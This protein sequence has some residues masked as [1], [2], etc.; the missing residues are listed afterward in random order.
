MPKGEKINGS[1]DID[2]NSA[3]EEQI[4]EARPVS[5]LYENWFLDYA[6]Y[7][8]L[9]RAVPKYDDGLKPVQRR[10]LHAMKEMDDG[11]FHKVANIIGQTMQYHPHG[12]AAIGDALVNM[13]QKDMLINT[14]GNWGDTRTG[15]SAAA[16]R[17]IEARLSKFAIDVVFNKEVTEWQNSYD[18]R[19]QEPV[20]LPVK[21]PMLLTQGVEGIAVGLSTKIMP[22]NFCE[23]IK[24]SI[25]SLNGKKTKL[26]PD[27]PSGGMGDFTQYNG[28]SKGGK[29]RLRADIKVV[30]KSTLSIT[31]V[32][33]NTTTGSLIDTILKANV[34]GKIKIKKVEDNTAKDVEILVHLK[35]GVSSD[36]A[37]DALFAFT[38]CEVSI[39]PNCCV[40]INNTPRFLAVDELLKMSTDNTVG[41]LQKELEIQQSVL[42]DKWH[43]SSLERVFIE[44]RIYSNIED[45]ETWEE[46]LSTIDKGLDPFKS[47]FKR[48]IIEE[49]LV[50]LTELK[51]K[52]ISKY[53][54]LKADE[55]IAKIE[56]N[57]EEVQ[58][59][60]NH[61]TEYAIRYFEQILKNH[62]KGRER[63]TEIAQFD[64]IKARRVAAA[65]VKL[66]MNSEDG[67]VGTSLRKDEFVCDCSDL[68]DIIIIRQDGKL[69]V[70]R[71]GE[72]TFVGKDIIHAAIWK[73][74]DKHMVYNAIYFDGRT[75]ISYAK[76]F[77]VTSIIRDREYDIT[78]GSDKSQ[79]LYFTANPNSESEMVIVNLHNSVKAR[80]KTFDFNFG[81]L[82][83][84][85]RGSKGN[86]VS[87]HRVRKVAQKEVGESTLGGRDIWLD[88]NIGRLNTDKQGRYLGS[89]NTDDAIL[90]IYEDGSYELANFELTNRFKLNEI[91][92]IE[93]F[94]SDRVLTAVHFEGG[95]RTYYIKRFHIETTTFGRLFN[96]ISDERTSKLILVSSAENPILE[97]SYRTKRGEKKTRKENLVQFV[98]IKGWKALGNKL[99]NY[100]RMSGFKWIEELS[101]VNPEIDEVAKSEL[102]LFN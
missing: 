18:G 66:Y 31:S 101:E 60:L 41:L 46:V 62:G 81:E 20:A 40:I 50:R 93:K 59:N 58:N 69:I 83:I 86:I 87:K 8:I 5:R 30:D 68:D 100:L 99:G 82:A 77:S 70:T 38:N 63:K 11:R 17:Y 22:H 32:P 15:D 51:I 96:F 95:S 14:Q 72:K 39:S 6:S 7:V 45:C 78:Q 10:I 25:D 44:N 64:T 91:S 37:I 19:K 21:F 52:R 4:Q 89:F 84:K 73:K 16:P 80:K 85:G 36:V 13:G 74:N 9:E 47:Q 75:G 98:E 94:N 27:F 23:L 56:S 3:S 92:L 97:Y 102:T 43:F 53:D 76:R 29:I 54:S 28:G 49:D 48:E 55:L 79:L 33:Y 90:I 24:G 12:D 67:F 1:Q 2:I 26:L 65:N 42:K 61:L 88:E 71:I 35:Q 57:L 34:S